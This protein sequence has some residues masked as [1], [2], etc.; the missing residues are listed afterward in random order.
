MTKKNKILDFINPIPILLL[1]YLAF[2]IYTLNYNLTFW[3]KDSNLLE[4]FLGIFREIC[5]ILYIPLWGMVI[6][7]SILFCEYWIRK[8]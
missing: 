1:V 8:K 7:F 6:Y 3:L 4:I 2:K 5:E